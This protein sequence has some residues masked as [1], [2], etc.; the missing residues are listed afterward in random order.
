ME[1]ANLASCANP[2]CRNEFKRLGEGKLF[3]R[4]AEKDDTGLKQKA[5]WLCAEC[6]QHFDLRYDRHL[7]E[8]SLIRRRRV[9]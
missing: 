7:Q 8:Y 4:P 3:V 1:K 2:E 6:A 5:L 9:A